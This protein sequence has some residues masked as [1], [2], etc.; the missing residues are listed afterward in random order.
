DV[1]REPRNACDRIATLDGADDRELPVLTETQLERLAIEPEVADDQNADGR[2]CRR[3]GQRWGG[4]FEE[5][6]CL[7]RIASRHEI[8]PGRGYPNANSHSRQRFGCKDEMHALAAIEFGACSIGLAKSYNV[9]GGSD[10]SL[11]TV[12]A[13][14]HAQ[15]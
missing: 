3:G 7:G 14:D 6:I 15:T 12:G 13:P 8:S 9:H 5:Q 11:F 10:V 2:R 1:R 4:T